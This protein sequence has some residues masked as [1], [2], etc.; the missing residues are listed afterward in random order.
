VL[1]DSTQKEDIINAGYYPGVLF[2][3][4]V[5]AK[6]IVYTDTT[7]KMTLRFDYYDYRGKKELVYNYNININQQWFKESL[8]ILKIYN[9][10]KNRG[11]YEYTYEVPGIYFPIKRI[12]DD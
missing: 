11:I 2:V 1:T 8:I 9:I 3:N 5:G 7:K 10:N 12:K 4:S 6:N